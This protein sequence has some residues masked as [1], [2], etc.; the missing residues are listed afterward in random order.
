MSRAHV[1]DAV[2]RYAEAAL[3]DTTFEPGRTPVPVAAKVLDAADLVALT[4]AVLDGWLTEGRFADFVADV[5]RRYASAPL[6][7]GD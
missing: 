3:A 5:Q 2:R 4:D 6:D 1:L 7:E